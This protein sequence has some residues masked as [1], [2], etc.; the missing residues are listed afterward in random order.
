MAAPLP[1]ASMTRAQ[2][3]LGRVYVNLDWTSKQFP[4][5]FPPEISREISPKDY[6]KLI[7]VLNQSL[8]AAG[9]LHEAAVTDC[10]TSGCCEYYIY[11]PWCLVICVGA[12]SVCCG[13]PIVSINSNTA[14]ASAINTIRDRLKQ[15]NE[16]NLKKNGGVYTLYMTVEQA[17]GVTDHP[18][19]KCNYACLSQDDHSLVIDYSLGIEEQESLLRN[20]EKQFEERQAM[21]ITQKVNLALDALKPKSLNVALNGHKHFLFLSHMKDEAGLIATLFHQVLVSEFK[22]PKDLIFLDTENLRSIKDLAEEMR[23]SRYVVCLLTKSYLTRPWCLIEL[24]EAIVHEKALIPVEVL[25]QHYDYLEMKDFLSSPLF[26][27]ELES[28]NKGACEA[29]IKEGYNPLDIAQT[30]STHL[31]YLIAKP[32]NPAA[33]VAVRKA[34]IEDIFKLALQEG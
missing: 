3:K 13:G 22:I 9:G 23:A 18:P 7:K 10:C 29:L 27:D 26:S 16:S 31:P 33:T 4:N 30:I 5:R 20:A 21:E 11:H 19:V 17:K 2:P 28:K 6:D 14:V 12:S 32:F 1:E 24:Y 34:Q 25:G 8:R 15:E